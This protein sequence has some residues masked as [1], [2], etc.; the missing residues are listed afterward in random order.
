MKLRLTPLADTQLSALSNGEI[1]SPTIMNKRTRLPE[2]GGL[3][4]QRVFGPVKPFQCA[5]KK[6][7]GRRYAGH[8]CERCGVEIGSPRLRSQRMGHIALPVP[9]INP[10]ALVPVAQVLDI[11]STGLKRVTEGRAFV[12]VKDDPEGGVILKNPER[13]VSLKIATKAT[14]GAQRSVMPF[15]T[16]LHK[17]NL[18]KT[19]SVASTEKRRIVLQSVGKKDSRWQDWFVHSVVLPPPTHRPVIEGA[20]GT[21]VDVRNELYARLISRKKR[22]EQVLE[23][24]PHSEVILQTMICHI[25]KTVN[26]IYLG[27]GKSM[28]STIP[29][30]VEILSS[31]QGLLRGNL[32]G[33]RVDYSGR[34]VIVPG[35]TLALDEMGLPRK[36]AYTL[37]MPFIIHE[38]LQDED[39]ATYEAARKLYRRKT[40][41]AVAAMERVVRDKH[42][43][44]NRQP[45]LHRF[46]MLAFRP[47]LTDQKAIQIPPMVCSPFNADFDGDTMAVHV[48]LSPQSQKE[49]REKMSPLRIMLGSLNGSAML[50]PTH[51]MVIGLYTMTNIADNKITRTERSFDRVMFIYSQGEL[52]LQTCFRFR[53]KTGER[54]TCVGRLMVED[55]MGVP[56]ITAPLTKRTIA[57]LVEK[58]VQRYPAQDALRRLKRLQETA[59]EL[60][61]QNSISLTVKD[62][63]R[64]QNKD[65]LFAE[66]YDFE[67]LL[68]SKVKDGTLGPRDAYERQVRRWGETLGQLEQDF[69]QEAGEDNSLIV[70]EKTGARASMTQIAQLAISKGLTTDTMNRIIPT[71]IQA[72]LREGLNTVQYVVSCQG[73]RKSLADKTSATPRSGYL[74]RRLVSVAR[75]LYITEHD[76]GTECG[77]VL[78][79]EHAPGR[80]VL[81]MDNKSQ[82][83]VAR[84]PMFCES[85]GGICAACYGTDPSTGTTVKVGTPIGVVAAQ[86]LTEPT[87]QMTMRTFHTSGAATVGGSLATRATEGG[88]VRSIEPV[89]DPQDPDAWK[90]S[91]RDQVY[92]VHR[93]ATLEVHEGSVLP[94]NGVIAVYTTQSAQNSGKDV[95]M[96]NED[97]AGKL[98]V[99]ERYYELQVHKLPYIAVI[100]DRAGKVTL[101]PAPD[102]GIKILVGGRIM[103]VVHNAPLRVVE[104][105]R[106]KRGQQLSH[107]EI[108]VAAVYDR[109][110]DLA[111]ATKLFVHRVME[112]YQEE[113]IRVAPV[114]LE[115]IF[116]AMT[117]IVEK[118]DGNLGLR[119]FDA[120]DPQDVLLHGVSD[121]CRHNPSWLKKATFGWVKSTLAE[122]HQTPLTSYDLP[123]E[124]LMM[125]QR[126]LIDI[127]PQYLDNGDGLRH[128][129]E[130][131]ERRAS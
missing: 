36:M 117:E 88:K 53:D 20:Q 118:A 57:R 43:L 48:P 123:T 95:E 98:V 109:T 32:L 86:S 56:P 5:C 75:D 100:S 1:V 82:T 25:Q 58:T 108:D 61:T 50:S 17:I 93:H 119:R 89:G 104:G 11:T 64:P 114:H 113:G 24:F 40:P 16:V 8:V 65:R 35:P 52:D 87:T 44:L 121:A 13:R 7:T 70:M 122:A 92:W 111:L 9:V 94:L 31:K 97:I 30:I 84:S 6:Y 23:R 96:A 60:A 107:G 19:L 45:T 120:H 103:G 21:V 68:Q 125:G 124:R 47:V 116:R 66:G 67:K 126:D 101:R 59:L 46:G 26:Q 41:E 22:A 80:H 83:I 85:R 127:D 33:K 99:L 105:E 71:P 81:E 54:E 51:E 27:G 131:Q 77:V 128:R 55:I 110:G 38:L 115:V 28:R 74:T 91:V 76:C 15:L 37:F 18:L 34:A 10:L 90:V 112:L 49:A 62:F 69:R 79:P 102:K 39:V 12:T 130:T 2:E 3:F 42:V 78:P 63:H 14:A 106:V 129:P 72:N 73:A 29:G 4:A